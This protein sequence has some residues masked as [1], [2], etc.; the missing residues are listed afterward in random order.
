MTIGASH[1]GSVVAEAS[2]SQVLFLA[3]G[4]PYVVMAINAA[5]SVRQSGT[6]AQIKLI[7]NH[8]IKSIRICDV[9]VFDSIETLASDA[10]ENRW[11]K[12]RIIDHADGAKNVYLDCDIEVKAPLNPI[13]GLLDNFEIAA[14]PLPSRP[15]WRITQTGGGNT[16][17][18]SSTSSTGGSDAQTIRC[19]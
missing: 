5:Q 14:R 8:P 15:A 3:M 17:F 9:D 4:Y 2:D 1:G 6:K 11:V 19:R 18:P 12:T 7:T 10:D 16:V 13:L